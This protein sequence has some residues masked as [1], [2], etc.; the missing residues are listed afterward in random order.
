MSM[1]HMPGP[2]EYQESV[3]GGNIPVRDFVVGPSGVVADCGIHTEQTAA[4]A[5]LIARAPEMLAALQGL[6][7]E[8]ARRPGDGGQAFPGP[9]AEG[10]TYRMWL[11]GLVAQGLVT[12]PQDAERSF[13]ETA[14][15]AVYQADALI[16]AQGFKDH[17][18]ESS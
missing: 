14:N 12:Q 1:S 18:R 8:L 2:W 9:C 7:N 17:A 4:N 11:V 15:L 3:S 6:R 16:A 13:E 5:R 10:M